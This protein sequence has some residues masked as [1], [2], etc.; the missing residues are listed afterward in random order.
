MTFSE[1]MRRPV[2]VAQCH[3]W[4]RA[5]EMGLCCVRFRCLPAYRD[6]EAKL[7][8]S[9]VAASIKADRAIGRRLLAMQQLA[10]S[11]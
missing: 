4:R 5:A 1:W 3:T 10:L 6:A 8:R 9:L 11:H 7:A 2:Y